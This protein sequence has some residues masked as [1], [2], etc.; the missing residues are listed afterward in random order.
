MP[1]PAQH[2]V[3]TK[4]ME[5]LRMLTLKKLNKYYNVVSIQSHQLVAFFFFAANLRI[6]NTFPLQASFNNFKGIS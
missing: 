5:P 2:K 4:K 3:E 6:A 1:A